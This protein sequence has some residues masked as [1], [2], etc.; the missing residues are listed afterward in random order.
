MSKAQT[1][2][3][4]R[5]EKIALYADVV[6]ESHTH[7]TSGHYY[8]NNTLFTGQLGNLLFPLHHTVVK[9]CRS[10]LNLIQVKFRNK[11]NTD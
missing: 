6:I 8:H 5:F 10:I 2:L 1:E 9:H 3:K 11:V 7:V 4:E